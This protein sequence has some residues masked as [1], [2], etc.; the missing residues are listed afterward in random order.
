MLDH[1]AAD[2]AQIAAAQEGMQADAQQATV[3]QLQAE[4]EDARNQ[5]LRAHAEL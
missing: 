5:T 2:E 1:D 3:E 4:V